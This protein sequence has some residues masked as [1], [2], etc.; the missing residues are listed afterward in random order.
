MIRSMLVTIIATLCFAAHTLANE[1]EPVSTASVGD[2]AASIAEPLKASKA[3]IA[4]IYLL[5]LPLDAPRQQKEC[6]SNN[7]CGSGQKCCT[8]GG[9]SWC[10]SKSKKCCKAYGGC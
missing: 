9:S 2:S 7:D 3:R 6:S 8:L 4:A 5:T 10:W 1:P